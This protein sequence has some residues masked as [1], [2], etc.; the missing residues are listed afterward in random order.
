MSRK[1]P[2]LFAV[3]AALIHGFFTAYGF[4]SLNS[5]GNWLIDAFIVGG[6]VF[7]GSIT[8]FGM[9]YWWDIFE[10]QEDE[11]EWFEAEVAVE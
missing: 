2:H 11:E 1:L 3:G 8:F 5:T 10:N 4:W 9:G 7:L 6:S